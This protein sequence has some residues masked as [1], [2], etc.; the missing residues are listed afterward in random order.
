MTKGATSCDRSLLVA[1]ACGAVKL[2]CR[3]Y[4]AERLNIWSKTILEDVIEPLGND[5]GFIINRSDTYSNASIPLHYVLCNRRYWELITSIFC[6]SLTV[7]CELLGL[8][9]DDFGRRS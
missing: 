9:V 8:L 1:L 2:C 6:V 5:P 4:V 7:T 3:W